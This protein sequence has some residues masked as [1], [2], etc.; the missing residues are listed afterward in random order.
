LGISP[1]RAKTIIFAF[2]AF[3]AVLFTI[4]GVSRASIKIDAGDLFKVILDEVTKENQKENPPSEKPQVP[5]TV[6]KSPQPG[7]SGTVTDISKL[8]K[9]EVTGE[10]SNED[11]NLYD[12]PSKKGKVIAQGYQYGIMGA[13]YYIVEPSP[14]KNDQ[15]GST[16][17]KIL[18]LA[19]S[20]YDTSDFHHA[21]IHNVPCLYVNTKAVK[22]IPLLKEDQDNLEW[23]KQGQ[24]PRFNVGDSFPKLKKLV[25]QDEIYRYRRA[26]TKIPLILH[27]EPK[28]ESATF[29]LPANSS[30][31]D[32]N[33]T[34][35][36]E[37][38]G[39]WSGPWLGEYYD[40]NEHLW[41]AVIDGKSLKMIG[42]LDSNDSGR[43][44]G[45]GMD[46][47]GYTNRIIN[48]PPIG[49]DGFVNFEEFTLK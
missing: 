44:F 35:M 2:A 26:K 34:R 38:K 47:D 41:F 32:L 39:G 14:L 23:F 21:I 45:W 17:Y 3:L 8:I 31:V 25:G 40:M 20:E 22:K 13:A 9:V 29:Q 5:D 30:V 37:P 4:P 6:E 27:E 15:E 33:D 43:G 11:T 24:P 49:K 42:W 10:D 16:W 18:F 12:K 1:R 28:Q 36:Y 46:N 7:P 19:G 48:A